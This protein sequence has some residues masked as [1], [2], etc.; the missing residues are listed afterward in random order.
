[1]HEETKHMTSE[2]FVEYIR[3]EAEAARRE[4]KKASDRTRP[5]A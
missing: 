1:M 2:E 3:R 4:R 5:A